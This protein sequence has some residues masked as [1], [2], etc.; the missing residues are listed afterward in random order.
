MT[1]RVSFKDQQPDIMLHEGTANSAEAQQ[2]VWY[3]D[4]DVQSF[5]LEFAYALR[6]LR[7]S[8]IAMTRFAELNSRDTAAFLGFE[9]YLCEDGARG[10]RERRGALRRAVLVEQDRQM[11]LSGGVIHDP[12]AIARISAEATNY[13]QIRAQRIALFHAEKK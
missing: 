7:S 5:K 13:S 2:V 10:I 1:K 3:S 11:T 8:P 4:E 6:L 12:D 9:D